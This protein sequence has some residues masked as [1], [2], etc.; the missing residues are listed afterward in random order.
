MPS[1]QISIHIFRNDL[2][3]SDNPAMSKSNDLGMVLPIFIL[4]EKELKTM[5]ASSKVW[6]YYSLKNLNNDIDNKILFF[7]G[8]FFKILSEIVKE[9]NPIAITKS[10]EYSSY[11]KTIENELINFSYKHKIDFYNINSSLLWEPNKI[12]KSDNTNYKVFTPFYKNGC[13]LSDKPRKPIPKQNINFLKHS[14]KISSI[15]KL[16]LLPAHKWYKNL[17]C[18]WEISE[19]GAIRNL[20]LFVNSYLK[21]YKDSRNYPSLDNTSRLSP[22]LHFGNISPNTVWYKAKEKLNFNDENLKTFLSELGWREF[23]YN[24]LFHNPKLKKDNLQIKFNKFPW[25]NDNQKLK[26]WKFG[27]TGYP[28]VDAGMRQL[29]KTGFMHNRLRMIVGSF[30]VKNLLIHWHEGEKW[31]W[32]TL[33]DADEAS[34]S[35]GWQWIAGCGADAAPFF[36]IFNPITQGEKFDPNGEYTK[37][38]VP[39]LSEMPNKFLYKPW[40][41]PKEILENSNVFLGENYPFPIIDVKKS[42]NDALNAF[43]S[44]KN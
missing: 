28:I 6:L 43:K 16:D 7:K 19:R 18:N 34:N 9:I 17:I 12:L 14:L 2:R 40:E 38:Y 42:R 26:A 8:D 3:L 32:E 21:N 20:D 15:H 1:K 13:L 25:I 36:R 23:S 27:Q 30:L 35:A 37:K 44:I 31:F 11:G 29:Y 41:A 10:K 22:Y 24:L 39:E 4:D 5:G 33:F